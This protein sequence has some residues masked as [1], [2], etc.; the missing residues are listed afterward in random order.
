MNFC[1]CSLFLS[2]RTPWRTFFCQNYEKVPK[3]C[4]TII[5][6]SSMSRMWQLYLQRLESHPLLTKSLT[7]GVLSSVSDVVAQL[8][9]KPRLSATSSKTKFQLD[10]ESILLQFTNGTLIRGPLLHYWH[11]L[12][13]RLFQKWDRKQ[14]R[15]AIVMM[16]VDQVGRSFKQVNR[17]MLTSPS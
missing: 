7:T 12:L 1:L 15:T 10:T 2:A 16:L 8:L 11:S 6:R 17:V 9:K 13:N 4:I 3:Q 14:W 5:Y